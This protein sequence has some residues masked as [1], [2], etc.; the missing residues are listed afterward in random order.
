MV[1]GMIFDFDGTLINSI[2]M[3]MEVQD[4]LAKSAGVVITPEQTRV[5]NTYTIEEVGDFFHKECG[6]AASGAEVVSMIDNRA[7][8]H[9]QTKVNICPGIPEL[10]EALKENNVA[11]SVASSSPLRFLTAGLTTAGLIDYFDAIVSVEE[12][13]KSKREPAVY[14]KARDYMNTNLENTWVVEDSIYALDTVSRAGY[15]SIGVYSS[16]ESGTLPE[17]KKHA[18]FAVSSFEGFDITGFLA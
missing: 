10:L 17:L 13:G 7:L 14:D 15:K 16:D 11:M 3:W 6:L 9:F 18:T 8:K 4:S 2:D 5:L 1:Q 12:V